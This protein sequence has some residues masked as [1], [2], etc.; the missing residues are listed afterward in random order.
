LAF[1]CCRFIKPTFT[2]YTCI[3]DFFRFKDRY[4]E[5]KYAKVVGVT[6]FLG[7]IS[8]IAWTEL[9]IKWN[10]IQGVYS[11]RSTGQMVLSGCTLARVLWKLLV[12]A[13]PVG[14]DDYY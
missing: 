5:T 6:I 1:V 10:D 8:L 4:E 14:T 11:V 12:P 9:V 3:T 7:A 2:P 13:S